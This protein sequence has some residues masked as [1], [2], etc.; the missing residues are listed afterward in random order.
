[1]SFA[2]NPVTNTAVV[3]MVMLTNR[4]PNKQTLLLCVLFAVKGNC[5]GFTNLI[6]RAVFQQSPSTRLL[7]ACV[8]WHVVAE[9]EVNIDL[10]VVLCKMSV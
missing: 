10:S 6:I 9:W 7:V 3:A 1:M 4:E 2:K 5:A 8:C